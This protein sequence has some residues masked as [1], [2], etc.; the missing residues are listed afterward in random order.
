MILTTIYMRTGIIRPI[1]FLIL[2]LLSN[3]IYAQEKSPFQEAS[4]LHRDYR[5]EE[6]KAAYEKILGSTTDSLLRM[7][8]EEAIIQCENGISLLHYA[9]TPNVLE[10]K[11]FPTDKFYLHIAGLEDKAWLAAPNQMMGTATHKYYNAA[12]FPEGAQTIYYSA[13]DNSG[14]WNIYEITNISGNIWSEPKILGENITSSGDEIFPMLSPNG[15]ELYFASNGHYGMGGFDLYVSHWDEDIQDWG[16]PENLGFPYSSTADD[17]FFINTPDGQ[18][19]V[20]ASTRSSS[21]DAEMT[22]YALEYTPTPIKKEISDIEEVQKVAKLNSSILTLEKREEI[23]EKGPEEQGMSEY[24]LL[25][26]N[27]RSLQMEMD[28]NIAR[29]EENRLLYENVTNEDDKAYIRKVITSLEADAIAI[30]ERLDKASAAVHAAEMD[31]LA[32]GIIPQIELPG[33]EREEKVTSQKNLSY[34]FAN[35]S[36]KGQV[37][38]SIEIPEPEFDYSFKILD[39]A[40]FAEDNTLPDRLIYQIQLMVVSKPASKKALKGLSP[41]FELK[42]PSGKY[43]YTV[44]LW[45]THAEAL[46]YLNQVRKR[47]FPKAYIVAYNN[48]KSLSVKN[49]RILERKKGGG[50]DGTSYQVVIK[51][52]ADGIPTGILTAIRDACDKDLA[53]SSVNGQTIYM[54][55]PFSNKGDADKLKDLLFGLGTEGLSVES[56]KK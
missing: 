41:V 56:I 13:P 15:K 32:K 4:A 42:Q 30:K 1:L 25:V 47:G 37:E 5:F 33:E 27:V 17:I 26:S 6:A 19:S 18:F 52:Y 31:F 2:I 43:L 50:Q 20:L 46:K 3:G 48:G 36:Y 55:G 11:Q 39:E 28:E 16:P 44:G 9:V 7:R 8:I 29:Q 23:E 45:G 35:N 40:Q 49:A 14:S 53:K 10:K 51:G 38:M 22:L 21:N 12:Y 54:V 34:K 24:A